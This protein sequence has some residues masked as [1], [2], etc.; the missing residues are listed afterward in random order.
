MALKSCF[1]EAYK[2]IPILAG[3]YKTA[4]EKPGQTPPQN[5]EE[6][7]QLFERMFSVTVKKDPDTTGDVVCLG[8]KRETD[9]ETVETQ[10]AT[11]KITSMELKKQ[12]K[13]LTYKR[14]GDERCVHIQ[15]P[16]LPDSVDY[17][18][19][20]QSLIQNAGM[21]S[22]CLTRVKTGE[23]KCFRC[24][25]AKR[26]YGT[27][28]DY[29]DPVADALHK[30]KYSTMGE[31][32]AKR[33]L[34]IDEI[35]MLIQENCPGVKIPDNEWVVRK[36]VRSVRRTKTDKSASTS[37]DEDVS[38]ETISNEVE[39]VEETSQNIHQEVAEESV[40]ETSQNIHQEVAEES[41]EETSQNIH[42]EVVEESVEETSQNIPQEVV[43][44]SVEETSQNIP[45]EVVE[46][47][48]EETSQ[49][50]HQ[51]VAEESVEET[52]QNIHQEVAEESVENIKKNSTKNK[53]KADKKAAKEAEKAAKKAAKELEKEQK[54]AAKKAAKE[55][56]KEQKKAE[57]AK[58]KAEKEQKESAH[59]PVN[60]TEPNETENNTEPNETENN[61]E[62][63][64][65]DL[66]LSDLEDLCEE[67]EE[68]DQ[69]V[70][71]VIQNGITYHIDI[72]N[73]VFVTDDDGDDCHVGVWDP[74]TKEVK[75][76]E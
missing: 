43:E 38:V 25:K 21:F 76:K 63:N 41:V 51:E 2:S 19:T 12:I 22:P 74:E 75:I 8:T 48:V 29:R 47:S 20:C 1:P 23:D 45:Q 67:E 35:K 61:T 49:N 44:E 28:A 54:K 37:S 17:S 60:I 71:H 6:F 34:P 30:R 73:D 56:E 11:D 58:K 32:C 46:E 52:S 39:S 3:I 62:S 16:Y 24:A 7:E 64:E 65:P 50:I 40:E 13:N 26:H 59:E 31:W 70:N 68:E 14:D 5:S 36:K 15:I 57:K 55:L 9:T 72:E 4:I 42:Q 53:E 27:I 10:V 33:E 66:Q 18:Q 69:Y